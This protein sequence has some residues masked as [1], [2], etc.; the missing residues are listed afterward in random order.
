[1]PIYSFKTLPFVSSSAGWVNLPA[2]EAV[3]CPTLISSS[4][5]YLITSNGPSSGAY[6]TGTELQFIWYFPNIL[7]DP[8]WF[9]LYTNVT[10]SN[11]LQIVP[12][13]WVNP[14]Q[15][16]IQSHLIY[17]YSASIGTVYSSSYFNDGAPILTIDPWPNC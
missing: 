14:P 16:G 1:M 7:T 6:Y 15:S 2:L 13:Q 10:S 5:P 4:M 3:P 17:E 8:S 9:K 12:N 11:G